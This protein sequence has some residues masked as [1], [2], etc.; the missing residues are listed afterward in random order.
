MAELDVSLL[1][2]AV[3][4]NR[5]QFE[6]PDEDIVKRLRFDDS[7]DVPIE[8]TDL[9]VWA[10]YVNDDLYAMD[11]KVREFLKKIRYAREKKGGYRTTV[12]V[13]FAWIYGR[14]PEPKDSAA[15][16]MLHELM[17]YYCTSYTDKTTTHKGKKVTCAY[18][19]SKYATENK[20]AYS[21]KLRLEECKDGQDPWRKSHVDNKTKRRSSR[22]K[23]SADSVDADEPSGSNI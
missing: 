5:R 9:D 11:K 15:C 8:L 14:K 7:L 17:R 12:P 10:N 4:G 20:R 3:G 23:H 22:R 18:D 21:L 1:Y 19:F 2:D 13:V 16:R 6:K